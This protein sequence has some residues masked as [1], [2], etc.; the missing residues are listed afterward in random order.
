MFLQFCSPTTSVYI[1]FYVNVKQIRNITKKSRRNQSSNS[2]K[3]V[4]I[5]PIVSQSER[6]SDNQN[7]AGMTLE[8]SEENDP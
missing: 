3:F 4:N 6:L 8:K 7:V 2:E 5:S 1:I